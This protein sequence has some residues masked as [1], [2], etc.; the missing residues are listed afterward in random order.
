MNTIQKEA[1]LPRCV[2]KKELR[3]YFGETY[4]FIWNNIITDELLQGWGSSYKQIKHLRALPADLT[5]QIY[6]HFKITDLHEPNH[7]RI[8]SIV[9]GKEPS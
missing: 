1:Y 3:H 2:R 4:K 5:E 9:E 8:K 7:E 6:L